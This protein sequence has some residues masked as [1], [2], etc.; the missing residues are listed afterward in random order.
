MG[1]G[2]NIVI[3][4]I[5]GTVAN[6]DHRQHLLKGFKTWDLFFNALDKD[7]PIKEE[8]D[9]VSELNKKG[10]KIVFITGRPERYREKTISWLKKYFDFEITIFMRKD[11]DF[12]DKLL[13]KK[14]IFFENFS[15]EDI[16]LVIENDKELVSQWRKF[17]VT[18]KA[19]YEQ[20]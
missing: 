16:H 18:T 9:N 1:T 11:D 5:D 14:D 2:K 13:V 17:G 20:N 7:V 19:T 10:K 8:I 12:R 3:C 15:V 6:N 4:D